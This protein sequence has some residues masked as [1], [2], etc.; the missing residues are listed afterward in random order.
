MAT[1]ADI[2]LRAAARPRSP[3]ENAIRRTLRSGRG[4]FGTTILAL[5]ILLSLLTPLLATYDPVIQHAGDELQGPSLQYLLGTDHLGRDLFSRVLFGTRT[6]LLVGLVAVVLGAAIG[7]ST[8]L[9]AGYFGGIID[10]VVMR[11]YDALHA[12]P[13]I[14]LG[15]AVVTALG[16]STFNVA[17]AIAL[18]Q[19]PNFARITRAAV[20]VERRRN[21]VMAS[22]SLGASDTR[23]LTHHIL[24]NCLSPILVQ[25]TLTMTFA[26]LAEAS[27]SFL[28]LG[29]QPPTP[30]WGGMLA[31]S[32]AYLQD[33]PWVGIWPGLMLAI[34]LLGLNFLQEALRDALD[35][36]RA[37]RA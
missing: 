5:F 9:V 36:R 21:Y 27:L 23:V 33:A 25:L 6:A 22:V 28:G 16:P 8:G 3:L 11:I 29:A 34:L 37:E 14:L 18:S 19:L 4:K 7:V 2:D 15:I 20:L 13:T 10:A 31:E 30:S 1:S 32:R 24:P 26:I 35:P 12:F 17:Y